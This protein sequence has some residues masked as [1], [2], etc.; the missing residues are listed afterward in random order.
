MG[1][2]FLP[3]GPGLSVPGVGLTTQE[4]AAAIQPTQQQS[5]HSQLSQPSSLPPPPPSVGHGS[6]PITPVSTAPLLERP[7]VAAALGRARE[8]DDAAGR[9]VKRLAE[10][11]LT[12]N[13]PSDVAEILLV[14]ILPHLK[15][16]K[17]SKLS[18]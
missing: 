17:P 7:D 15:R 8:Y 9:G 2:G 13:P 11:Q 3:S 5:Q 16:K 12:P 14:L 18:P 6:A 10:A 1:P 4:I